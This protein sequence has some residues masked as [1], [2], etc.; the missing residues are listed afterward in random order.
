MITYLYV[1]KGD[2]I[3]C[4]NDVILIQISVSARTILK[5]IFVMIKK[6][7]LKIITI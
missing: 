1:Q 4:V 2:Y 3:E 7:Q 6:Q 5:N